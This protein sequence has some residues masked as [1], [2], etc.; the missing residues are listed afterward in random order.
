MIHRIIQGEIDGPTGLP[1]Q[2][3]QGQTS[4]S[5]I[6]LLGLVD[7]SVHKINVYKTENVWQNIHIEFGIF[8]DK[9]LDIHDEKRV[10]PWQ[11]QKKKTGRSWLVN[12]IFL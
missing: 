4:E 3:G 12:L 5:C 7:C 9:N 11:K 2:A 6:I 1:G 10:F 8:F